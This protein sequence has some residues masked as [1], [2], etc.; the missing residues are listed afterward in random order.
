MILICIVALA[1]LPAAPASFD[2]TVVSVPSGDL[3]TVSTG[4]QEKQVRLY[5]VDCPDEGQPH[6]DE[7]VAFVKRCTAGKTLTVTPLAND[8]QGVMVVTV[9][10]PETG[11]LHERLIEQ[12]LGWWDMENTPTDT[13]LRRLNAK[14]LLGH[15]GLWTES[16]PLAPWDYR[17]SHGGKEIT[18]TLEKKEEPPKPKAAE[19]A[20]PT[21]KAKGTK[22]GATPAITPEMLKQAEGLDPMALMLKH[23]PTFVRDN[24]GKTLGLTATNISQI[25][26][27][28]ALGFR[29]GDII[30]SVNGI[31]LEQESQIFGLATQLQGQKNFDIEVL[32]GGAPANI[33]IK[34]P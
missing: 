34:V 30:T 29:D 1:L 19:A 6:A 31:R 9:A 2:A 13:A 4:G 18:Y 12:G 20:V 8:N 26:L 10:V 14:A 5:G 25:P 28:S 15:V 11:M 24:A 3:L 16:I 21:L 17:K 32:R 33:H 7:A 22:I 23:A 27:A